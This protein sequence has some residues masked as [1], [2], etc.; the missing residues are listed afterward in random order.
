MA[1][2]AIASRA[3]DEAWLMH[4]PFLGFSFPWLNPW[5]QIGGS[6]FA[7]HEMRDARKQMDALLTLGCGGAR[8][9]LVTEWALGP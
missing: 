3:G 5:A 9:V 7:P 2:L 6:V 1:L 8:K 4:G